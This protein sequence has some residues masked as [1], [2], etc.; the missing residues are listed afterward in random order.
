M[1]A[2]VYGATGFQWILSGQVIYRR[3]GRDEADQVT[4]RVPVEDDE[5]G[6]RLSTD[7]NY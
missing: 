3:P 6:I 5:E 1:A 2:A 7:K 4:S